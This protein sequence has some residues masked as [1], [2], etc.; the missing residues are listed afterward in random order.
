MA[1]IEYACQR[2]SWSTLAKSVFGAAV[3]IGTLNAG[4]AQAIT[5]TLVNTFSFD[6]SSYRTYLADEAITWTQ[7]RNYALALGGGYDLV[8]VNDAAENAVV[9]VNIQLPSLYQGVLAGPYIGAYRVP[10]ATGIWLWVDGTAMTYTNWDA[11]EPSST[12]GECC[13]FLNNTLGPSYLAG[14]WHDT[15]DSLVYPAR[16]FVVEANQPLSAVPGPPTVLSALAAFGYSRK[17]RKRIN[18]N[19]N[20]N[21]SSYTI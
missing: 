18:S 9:N 19:A 3:A 4:Q 8:S 20:P 13:G 14:K 10:P 15:Y 21:S 11:G 1:K 17:L 2:P 6:S 7:A 12:S 16:S 5:F